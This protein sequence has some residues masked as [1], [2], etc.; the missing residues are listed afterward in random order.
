GDWRLFFLAR[1]RVEQVTLDDVN[2]V[3]AY[4]L[5][6]SN[7]TLGRFIPTAEPDRSEISEAKPAAELLEGYSGREAVAAGEAFEATPENIDARTQLAELS[8]GTKL[9]LLSKETRG[10][11]VVFSMVLR[12]G[13]EEEVMNRA[14]AGSMVAA[15]LT[16]GSQQRSREDI[17]RRFDELKAQ[18]GFSGSAQSVSVSGNTRREHLPE[19]LDL[20]AELLRSE[21]RRVGQASRARRS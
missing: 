14:L 3:A 1:D 17:A 11:T 5:K 21:E 8:N 12:F 2:R 7:R 20:I 18:V 15:M 4:Y 6:P 10:D 19:V 9:S 16:R 13:S